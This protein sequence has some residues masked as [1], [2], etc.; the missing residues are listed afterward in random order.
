MANFEQT[1]EGGLSSGKW[2]FRMRC[3]KKENDAK[4]KRNTHGKTAIHE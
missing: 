2:G 3:G 4:N 1:G